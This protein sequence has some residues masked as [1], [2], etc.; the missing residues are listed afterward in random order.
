MINTGIYIHIPFCQKKCNYCDFFSKADSEEYIGNYVKELCNEIKLCSERYKDAL[1]DTVYI[2]GGTPSLLTVSQLDE[3][4]SA[5]RK[6]FASDIIETTIEV[7]PNSSGNLKEYGKVGIDRVSIGV[8]SVNDAILKKLGRLHSSKE[9]LDAL[10]TAADSFKSVSA[11]IILGADS[12]QDSVAEF[13]AVAPYVT[14]IS[15]YMLTLENGTPLYKSVKEKS[16]SVATDDEVASQYEKFVR[17]AAG[18]GFFRYETSNFAML[19]CESKHNS[20]Y[21]NLSPYI[22]LG[23]GAHSYV[24]GVR[25]YNAE[26]IVSYIGGAHSGNGKEIIERGKDAKADKYEYVMLALRTFYGID[27]DFYNKTFSSDFYSEYGNKIKKVEKYVSVNNGRIH[28]LPQFFLVQNAIIRL[29][30][31]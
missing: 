9:A 25:Y 26:D 11:D 19:G 17:A 1:I 7:N 6:N 8:Q 4:L 20:R 15:A 27:V 31:L 23:A 29:I 14:H 16:V 3:I 22:G 21:W 2:G 18:K 13:S 5:V 30:L 10:K 12:N 24:N 28:I